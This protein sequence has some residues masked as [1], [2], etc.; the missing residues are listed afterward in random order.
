[1]TGQGYPCGHQTRRRGCGGC[2]PGAVEFVR[3]DGGPWRRAT[4][5]ETTV[6]VVPDDVVEA[7]CEEIGRAHV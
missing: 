1:M 3:D 7:A 5:D 2:D 6:P 4:A